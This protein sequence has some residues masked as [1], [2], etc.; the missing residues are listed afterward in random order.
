MECFPLDDFISN[1]NSYEELFDS[2]YCI[3]TLSGFAWES[4]LYG[5]K[6][7]MICPGLSKLYKK[8]DLN[9]FDKYIESDN[10]DKIYKILYTFCLNN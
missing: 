7:L 10:K 1:K 3:S 4:R 6:T 9:Y 2:D 8:M 5:K